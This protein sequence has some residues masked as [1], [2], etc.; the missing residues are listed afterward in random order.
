MPS[1][2][3]MMA[4]AVGTVAV[5]GGAYYYYKVYKPKQDA[6]KKK[7]FPTPPAGAANANTQ[8]NV[9]PN[10]VT[11]TA[12]PEDNPASTPSSVETYTLTQAPPTA[13]SYVLPPPPP[14]VSNNPS[15]IVPPA[16][17][18][19][20]SVAANPNIP[21][22][23]QPPPLQVTIAP[24]PAP[25][26]PPPAPVAPLP[27]FDE[28]ATISVDGTPGLFRYE[29]GTLRLYPSPQILTSWNAPS[30]ITISQS[31]YDRFPK[32][33]SMHYLI[34][35]GLAYVC[36]GNG[37]VF[38][39]YAPNTL[40]GYPSPEIASSW[41]AGWSSSIITIEDCTGL[42]Y[43]P[44]M[45]QKPT[46][47][48]TGYAYKCSDKGHGVYRSENT[49]ELRLYPTPDI[50]AS[51]DANWGGFATIGNCDGYVFGPNMQKR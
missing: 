17:I 20:S 21:I 33:A 24:P 35:D 40:R 22:E 44:P 42:N 23:T 8:T 25:I 4:G 14:P 45:P 6:A 19:T 16:D 10:P 30:A 50:A 3:V 5:V 38:R 51:W 7:A 31:D 28:G 43:G 27:V 34:K 48:R 26:A 1:K 47:L 46:H 29:G 13:P 49:H 11:P 18:P 36:K 9:T 15:A 2:K 41:D 12:A 39:G 37:V 32:G